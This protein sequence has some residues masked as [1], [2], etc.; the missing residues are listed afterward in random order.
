MDGDYQQWGLAPGSEDDPHFAGF[1]GQKCTYG[2]RFRA[3]QQTLFAVVALPHLASV[4]CAADDVTGEEN[5]P[6]IWCVSCSGVVPCRVVL[7]PLVPDRAIA[8]R[9]WSAR[10]LVAGL[11]ACSCRYSDVDVTISGQMTRNAEDNKIYQT[12]A[13]MRF[14]DGS[15]VLFQPSP[16]CECGTS[17]RVSCRIHLV[18]LRLSLQLRFH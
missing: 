18:P 7:L 10:L 9:V 4:G 12:A 15:T 3:W 8:N 17:Q 2:A 14:G 1:R 11:C 6:Y 5:V 16:N 13:A